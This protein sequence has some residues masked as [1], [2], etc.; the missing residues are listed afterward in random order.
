MGSVARLYRHPVKGLG[1]ESLAEA[2]LVPGRAMPFDRHWAIAPAGSDWDPETGGWVEPRHFVT[3][4]FVPGLARATVAWDE[5]ARR[6]ALSHPERGEIALDPDAEEGQAMLADWIGPL[7]E[8]R[9]P[10]PYRIA[11]LDTGGFTDDP[12]AHVSINSLSS[13]AALEQ[14]AGAELAHIRFRGNIWLDGLAPWEEFDLV[15]REIAIGPVR[16]HVTERIERC[17]ATTASPV[18]G[19]RDVPVPDILQ[20]QWGHRD[21]GVYA[22]V[23]EGGTLRLGDRLA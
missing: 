14:A 20:R 8:L 16:L 6:L 3:Q 10:G 1:E 9:R 19:A 5:A 4:T 15:G 21:F 7:A 18:S 17:N 12:D 13:L 11:R 23:I 22:E 2:A